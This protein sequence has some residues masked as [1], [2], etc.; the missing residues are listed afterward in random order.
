MAI[1]GEDK[2]LNKLLA[3]LY[4]TMG[5]YKKALPIL[6]KIVELD[7]KDHKAIWQI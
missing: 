5:T 4:F 1:D 2:D 6:K 7:P 3:D